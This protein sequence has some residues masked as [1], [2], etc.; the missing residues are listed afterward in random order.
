MIC[1][2]ALRFLTDYLDGDIYYR[3]EYPEQNYDRAKN[4]LALLQK[5]EEFLEK[6]YGFSI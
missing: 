6:Q 1:M 2:Q 4:Q 5:L 3:I